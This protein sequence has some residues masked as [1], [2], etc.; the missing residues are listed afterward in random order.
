MRGFCSIFRSEGAREG[1]G[2]RCLI[3]ASRENPAP[4]Q[5]K[6]QF[7]LF[8]ILLSS[9]ILPPREYS[10]FLRPSILSCGEI[11]CVCVCAQKREKVGRRLSIL[12]KGRQTGPLSERGV[13]AQPSVFCCRDISR[14]SDR[15]TGRRSEGEPGEKEFETNVR[16]LGRRREPLI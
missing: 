15:P 8:P 9:P 6:K 11:V 16:I 3:G 10:S 7:L 2:R 4:P 13:P 1:G 14:V 12:A 5:K